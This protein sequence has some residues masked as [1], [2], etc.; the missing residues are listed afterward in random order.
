M[1]SVRHADEMYFV[2]AVVVTCNSSWCLS[3][4]KPVGDNTHIGENTIASIEKPIESIAVDME[5]QKALDLSKAFQT[6]NTFYT[7]KYFR[8]Y[9]VLA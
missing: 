6:I 2:V 4:P 7:N 1:V 3:K 9:F 8:T 5:K